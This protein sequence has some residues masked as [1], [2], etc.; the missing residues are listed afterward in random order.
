MKIIKS[1]IRYIITLSVVSVMVIFPL[2]AKAA[3]NL[4]KADSAYSKGEYAEAVGYYKTIGSDKGWSSEL[5]YNLGNAYARGGDYGN[6]LV[7]YLRAL[8]LNPSNKQ[9]ANN[10]KYIEAKVYDSNRAELKGKKMS[11]DP[12]SFTFFSRVKRFIAL[13]HLSDTWAIWA[14]V[15]FVAF[16]VCVALYIFTRNVIVRKI[17]FFGG[18]VFLGVSVIALAFSFVAA[19]YKENEGAVIAGKARLRS[20]AS[21]SA[22]ENPVALTRGTRMQVLDSVPLHGDKAEW[23]KVRLNS[24]FVGWLPADEFCVVGI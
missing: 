19:D 21:A 6:A 22:K 9:A 4:A 2:F 13:D 5:F 16:A 18:I 20:E 8:R 24:D 7:N 10:V 1:D 12:D 15:M 17:G 23:Y 11:V 14:A 3:D